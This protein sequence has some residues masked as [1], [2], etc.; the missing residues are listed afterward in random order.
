M[1]ITYNT[2]TIPDNLRAY[3]REIKLPVND[4]DVPPGW[5][6]VIVYHPPTDQYYSSNT[7]R[8]L[9][10]H[11]LV[12]TKEPESKW[13][14]LAV[15]LRNLLTTNHTFQ[16]FV[17]H[18]RSRNIVE[19]WLAE[20]GKRRVTTR[21]GETA[22]EL[23]VLFKVFSE[24]NQ[25]A[26]YVTAPLSTPHEKIIAQANESMARWLGSQV[27]KDLAMRQTMRIALRSVVEVN[28]RV[29]EKESRVMA[30]NLI[31]DKQHSE[32]RVICRD[33][34]LLAIKEFIRKTTGG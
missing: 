19:G 3:V 25:V 11:N 7:V 12:L 27:K 23:H 34:N 13:K 31:A 18:V 15:S 8:P 21:M 4:N 32:F 9:D 1:Q 17:L 24:N 28:H 16:F 6:G 5:T 20:M 10:Y 29:F 26:R 22:T 14:E 33:Q 30:T 2:L